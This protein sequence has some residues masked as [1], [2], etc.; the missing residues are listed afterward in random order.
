MSNNAFYREEI[1]MDD[2]ERFDET[3]FSMGF[4]D[5]YYPKILNAI[6]SN[7]CTIPQIMRFCSISDIDVFLSVL[8]RM[9]TNRLIEKVDKGQ[10]EFFF[11]WNNQPKHFWLN[12]NGK[13]ESD[14]RIFIK[15]IKEINTMQP[16]TTAN[17]NATENGNRGYAF[18]S[19]KKHGEKHKKDKKFVDSNE[20][21]RLAGEGKTLQEIAKLMEIGY[22]TLCAKVS[23]IGEVKA[24]LTRGRKKWSDKL[25]AEAEKSKPETPKPEVSKVSK[26]VAPVVKEPSPKV[27]VQFEKPSEPELKK[28]EEMF[29]PFVEAT[30]KLEYRS[31]YENEEAAL[32]QWLKDIQEK[33]KAEFK[34]YSLI[35][36]LSQTEKEVLSL[37]L[38]KQLEDSNIS[39][40]NQM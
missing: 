38:N 13:V 26:D 27:E 12:G 14:E 33:K 7:F 10:L 28:A 6:Q 19:M 21:E 37:I 18:D 25:N 36:P 39:N 11:E 20:V 1:D 23:S 4:Y 16:I 3:V 35:E 15:K 8:K 2:L 5:E 9:L 24:A 22:S 29:K 40:V 30:T 32:M 34:L 17:T 31:I